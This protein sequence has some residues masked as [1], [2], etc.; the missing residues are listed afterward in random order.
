MKNEDQLRQLYIRHYN[1]LIRFA[2]SFVKNDLAEDLVQ[3]TFLIAQKR[4][5]RVLSSENPTG[6][7]INTQKNVIGNTYQRRQFIYTK[8]I[9]ET[10]IDESGEYV[11][12]VNDM[13]TGLIDEEALSLLIWVYC[14]DTSYQDA[15]SRL[16]ISL[17]ACKKRIQRAKLALKKAIEKNNLL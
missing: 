10:A 14:E 6:W 15:A 16:G 7:L 3:E 12:S 8:L 1:D 2:R 9:P 5:D 11:Y 13:Y 4:L 17:S